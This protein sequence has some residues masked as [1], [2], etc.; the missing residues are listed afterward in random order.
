MM[1]CGSGLSYV[2]SSGLQLGSTAR[3]NVK[4]VGQ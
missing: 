2:I 1:T 3:V 4:D